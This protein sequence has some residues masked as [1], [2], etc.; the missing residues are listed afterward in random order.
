[1]CVV[2]EPVQDGIAGHTITGCQ[3]ADQHFYILF[4]IT[5]QLYYLQM[6]F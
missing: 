3:I 6:F 5:T 4:V 1:M 2:L